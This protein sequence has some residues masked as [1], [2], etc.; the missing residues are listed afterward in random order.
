V[1]TG[2]LARFLPKVGS[3]VAFW[4]GV[5][6]GI[7]LIPVYAFYFLMEK[8]GIE[9]KW[10]D[11]LPVTKSEFKDELVFVLRSV[12]DYLIVFFRG[13]VLVA[14]CD[15]VLYTIGFVI[16]GLPYSVLLGVLAV[17]LTLI[18]FLGAMTT[19]GLA[20]ILAFAQYGDWKHPALVLAV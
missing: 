19:C 11:Y 9:S 15:G 18:P 1:A 20:L 10:T 4:F 12:N 13:Q 16:I 3:W 8:Q 5:L 2:W 17:G 6:A 14:I 7:A